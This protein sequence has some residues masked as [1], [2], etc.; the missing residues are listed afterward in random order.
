MSCGI[1]FD[2]IKSVTGATSDELAALQGRAIIGLIEGYLG[3]T[4]FKR[5]FINERITVPYAHS[6]IFKVKHGPLNS[7]SE[8]SLITCDADY[9]VS[10]KSLQLGYKAVEVSGKLPQGI[11]AVKISYNAGLYADWWE[12]PGIIQ[13]AAIDLL[14]YKFVTDSVAGF[15]SEHLGDYSYSKGSIVRGLPAEI[16]GMLDGVVL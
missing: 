15:T 3:V 7:V 16:A 8:M 2:L 6:K 10:N 5:D 4:L 14:K 13:Q 11:A 1:P 9:Q 12:V